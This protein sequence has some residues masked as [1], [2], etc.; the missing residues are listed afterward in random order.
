MLDIRKIFRKKENVVETDKKLIKKQTLIDKMQESK[1]QHGIALIIIFN[2]GLIGTEKKYS[3]G[4]MNYANDSDA[5]NHI[6]EYIY[7]VNESYSRE[8]DYDTLNFELSVGLLFS[9]KDA[10]ENQKLKEDAQPI[11][12]IVRYYARHSSCYLDN[13]KVKAID[14]GD[15]KAVK[16]YINYD[17]LVKSAEDN[18]LVFNGPRTFEEFKEYILVGEPFSI[19]IT[20]SLKPQKKEEIQYI[21]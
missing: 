7:E 10:D 18:G 9:G 20:A 21:K 5:F 3:T 17:I 12:G 13:Q 1:D 15:I 16:G 14:W 19:S 11:N 6:G 8:C 4:M 2:D